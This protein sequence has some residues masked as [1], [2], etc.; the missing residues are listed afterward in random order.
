MRIV[1]LYRPIR[2]FSYPLIALAGAGGLFYSGWKANS[3]T[4]ALL[5]SLP[6]LG[7]FAAMW[8][9]LHPGRSTVDSAQ[10]VFAAIGN[11]KPT[12]LNVFSNY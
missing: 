9:W 6:A 1:Q 12:L 11:G 2:R 3:L 4:S 5:W 7:A 8:Y 10:D